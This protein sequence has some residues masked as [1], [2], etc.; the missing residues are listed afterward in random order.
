MITSDGRWAKADAARPMFIVVEAKRTRTLVES[1]S[2][3]ELI[4]HLKSQLIRRY[5]PPQDLRY[6]P[7][8]RSLFAH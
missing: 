5:I 8:S 7:N 2:E 4:D 1:S 6:H 3:A